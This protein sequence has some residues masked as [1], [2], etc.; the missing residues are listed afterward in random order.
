MADYFGAAKSLLGG[1]SDF[2]GGNAKAQGAE[3]AAKSYAQAAKLTLAQTDIKEAMLSRDIYKTLGGIRSSAS[4]SG[5]QVSGSAL[6]V[7]RD[8]TR[9]GAIA[10]AVTQ[11]QGEVDYNSLMGKS[12][13]ETAQAQASKSGGFLGAAGGILGAVGSIFGFSDDK[14]KQNVELVRRRSDGLGVYHFSYLGSNAVFE[15]AMASDVEAVRP[16]AIYYDGDLNLRMVKYGAIGMEL[17]R[18]S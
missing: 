4:A 12:K 17:R 11:L 15:G 16:D 18:I 2:I 13:A 7:L 14:L 10:K 3:E 8:S 9:Q 5:L 6:D 1:V